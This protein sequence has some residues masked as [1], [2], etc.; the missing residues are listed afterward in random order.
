MITHFNLRPGRGRGDSAAW[1]TSGTT[2][3]P[4]TSRAS[5]SSPTAAPI[6]AARCSRAASSSRTR[7]RTRRPPAART[8]SSRLC[9]GLSSF[10]CPCHGGSY[11]SEGNRTAGPPVRALDRWSYEIKNGNLVL[12]TNYSVSTV[13]GTGASAVINK[14]QLTGPGQWVDGPEQILYPFQPP[15]LMATRTKT[16]RRQTDRVGDRLSDRLARGA[17]GPDRRDPLLPLP[18]G[19][20]R[21]ELVPHARLGDAHRLP[22]PADHRRDPGDVL[23]AGSRQGVRV[24]PPH[25]RRPHARLARPRHAPL[26]RERASS[27]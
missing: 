23:Q 2:A 10:T 13:E 5:R 24:D 1:P 4:T 18:Q 14:Y 9:V 11:D 22:R 8:S 6:S 12:V 21:H 20:R 7:P 25:H 26:G 19:S 27:S 17:V 3:S 16:A 15:H